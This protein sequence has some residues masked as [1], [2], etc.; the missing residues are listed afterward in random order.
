VEH[1]CGR[2]RARTP[3]PVAKK[4]A[5]GFHVLKKKLPMLDFFG[6]IPQATR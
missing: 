2:G 4:F 1:E 3:Q 6:T 5:L